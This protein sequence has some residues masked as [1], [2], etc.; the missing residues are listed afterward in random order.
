MQ[1]SNDHLRSNRVFLFPKVYQPTRAL[2]EWIA[3]VEAVG[4]WGGGGGR[5]GWSGGTG[6]FLFLFN[7]VVYRGVVNFFPQPKT[8]K[9]GCLI[10]SGGG[11]GAGKG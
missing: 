4:G 2:N 11:V 9:K 8:Q 3:H 7:R 1:L 5:V 6:P 10:N